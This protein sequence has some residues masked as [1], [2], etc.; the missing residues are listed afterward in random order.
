V[1][2]QVR[3]DRARLHHALLGATAGFLR[4][5]GVRGLEWDTLPRWAAP[6][7]IVG[8]GALYGGVMA[9]YNGLGGDRVLMVAYGA[10]K[11]PLLFVATML[12]AVP[13]FYVLNLLLGVGDHFA[14]VWRALVDFQLAVSLQLAA[15]VPVT[16]FMNLTNGDYRV[17][18]AFSTLLFAG[19]TWNARRALA[20]AY[21]PLID[22]HPV[23]RGLLRTWIALYAFV[24]V[25][26]GWDLRPFVGSP[27]M[28]V[29]FFRDDIGNAYLEIFRILVEAVRGAAP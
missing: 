11:V 4:E 12:L 8:S 15:L 2:T 28:A 27:D 19:A 3:V 25:Q 9:S 26:M 14:R 29:Q 21:A 24:G 20:R 1:T 17:A 13:S 18:Q 22:A 10:A 5:S 7:L 16:A 6:A 23:H